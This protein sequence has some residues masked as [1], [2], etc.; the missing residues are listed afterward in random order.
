[1]IIC[2]GRELPVG[3]RTIVV[4]ILNVTPDSFSDGGRFIDPGAA[5]EHALSMEEQGA[6]IIDVG[7][8]S[9]RPGYTPIGPDEERKRLLPVLKRLVR[10]LRVPIS[11]DTYKAATAE[12]AL[13]EGAAMVNDVWGFHFDEKM[14]E[15]VARF[16]VP[17]IVMHNKSNAAYG[18]LMSEVTDF[19]RRSVSMGE[20]AGI[21][22]E[23][24]IVDPGIGFGKTA[25]HN[26][27]ILRRLS[28]LKA[29]GQPI[30]VGTS[31][32]SVIGKVLNLP[33]GQ[34]LEGT[35]ATVA[36]SIANGADF[37]R[38]HDVL[39][40]RRVAVMTDAIIRGWEEGDPIG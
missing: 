29:I 31:R 33:E 21:S 39:E 9:T 15:V 16:G 25:R 20:R 36:V 23:K 3:R 30:M 22:R 6:D 2:G 8:E 1:M 18:D 11:V 40:M 4:G 24:I 12:W 37:V 7:A 13:G 32:K 17:V 35:A 28:E 10:C 14:P 34:R 26:L 5:L 19:L 27:E 38:V